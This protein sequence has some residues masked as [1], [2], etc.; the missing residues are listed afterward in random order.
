VLALAATTVVA[1]ATSLYL[2]Y[3]GAV[4]GGSDAHAFTAGLRMTW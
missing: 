4:G 2:R 3:D 1:E